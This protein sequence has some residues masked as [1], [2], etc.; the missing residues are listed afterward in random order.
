MLSKMDAF[1]DWKESKKNV[2]GWVHQFLKFE[3][4]LFLK[5]QQSN[6]FHIIF[7]CKLHLVHKFQMTI[8]GYCGSSKQS[9]LNA[10]EFNE[11]AHISLYNHIS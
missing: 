6:N 10:S 5:P 8:Y 9:Q 2:W 7:M 11:A 4:Q 3:K 1:E